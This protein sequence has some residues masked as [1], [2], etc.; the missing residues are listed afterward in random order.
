MTHRV[1]VR[2]SRVCALLVFVLSTYVSTAFA[3]GLAQGRPAR[4]YEPGEV[5]VKF[6]RGASLVRKNGALGRIRGRV[7]KSIHT[8][9]MRRAGDAGIERV[10]TPMD[11]PAALRA[12][13]QDPNVE[14]AEPNW[15]YTTQIANDPYYVGGSL[16]GMYGPTTT[17]PNLYGSRAGEAWAAGHTGSSTVVVGVIDQGIQITHPDLAAN[18]WTN[19][20]ET[21]TDGSGNNKSTNGL[22]DD[23]N[24]YVDD[25]NGWD[26]FNNDKT[27]YDAGGDSHGTH[28]AGTIGGVGN[29]GAGVAG[30]NWSVKIIPAKFLGPSGGSSADAIEALDYLVDLK[31][32]YGLKLVATNNSWGGGSYSQFLHAAIIRAAKK[33]ILF[34]AAAGNAGSNNDAT[35]AYPANFNTTIA[36]GAETAASYDAVISVAAINSAGSLAGFSNYGASTV[37]LGAPG[38]DINSTFPGG[39]GSASGT[40]MA[41][42]HVTGA[43]ALFAADNPAATGAQIRTAILGNTVPSAALTGKSVTG[44]RLSVGG[45]FFGSPP[46]PPG[47]VLR[48]NC[49]GGQYVSADLGTFQADAYYSGGDIYEYGGSVGATNDPALYTNV[50]WGNTFGYNLPAASGSY[51]L[52][53]HFMEGYHSSPGQRV[54][55]V[56]VNG[57]NVLTNF[58]IVA[59]AGGGRVALVK[60]FPVTTAGNVALTF[61][62]VA[63]SPIVSAI[64]LIGSGGGGQNPPSPPGN[65]TATAGTGQVDLTWGA[66]T[67]AFSYNV[68]RGSAPGGPYGTI[69]AG[70][71]TTSYTDTTVTN[72]TTYYYVVTSVNQVA[73]S[74]P[75]NEAS[76]TPSAGGSALRIN[77]GG[78]QYVSATLGTF[79]ADAYFSG[80]D[81]YDYGVPVSGTSDDALYNS[82]RWANSFSYNLPAAS[83]SYTLKLHF[84][85][86][87]WN[88]SGQRV[89]NVAVNGSNVLTNFDIAAEA[90]GKA[91]LVKSIPATSNGGAVTV[92]FQG[93]VGAPIVSAIELIGSGGGEPPTPPSAPSGL[94]AAGGTGQVE[95]TWTAGAEAASYNVK[96]GTASGGPYGTVA[97]GVTTT[98]YTDTTVVNGTTYYYVVTSVN[99]QGE[100][101]PSNEASATPTAGGGALRI[102]CGGGQYVSPSLGTFQADAYFSGGDVYDYGVPVSGTTD[103]ALYNTV[104]WANN[105]SYNL[106][107]AGASYTLKLHFMEGYWHSPGQR[108]FNVAVNGSNVLTNFDIVAQAG[109]GK[110]ALVKTIPATSV[111]GTVTVTFQ[112]VNGAPIVSAIELIP[113]G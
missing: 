83:G 15:V 24:G 2:F 51:T 105:F 50:R 66:G 82:V 47:S 94:S 81:V 20:G 91:A 16:W 46:P 75:S 85:E 87:Y 52:K 97:T 90:G 70:V 27:V 49:G 86:G 32:R 71:T 40:S 39:Y 113:G 26:F 64:E 95:L 41:A 23:A 111:G 3:G 61:Q 112:A 45:A 58:D 88:T 54:F 68:K 28:V 65:L 38:V 84:M 11:V 93:V 72:G 53:L 22:D 57:S 69:A 34:I 31:N 110:T 25:V 89:F 103:D 43:A 12:L 13:S 18:I 100:S 55:N 77:C 10:T 60:S 1:P 35:P 48:I 29:N 7:R 74:G 108:V 21:G 17:P 6:R 79:Q 80:G 44:G 62:S 63:G 67:G 92:T 33:E 104:R 56:A 36:A 42:P 101:G 78:G 109:G 76:A 9:A 99:P 14:Y 106:P 98:S 19:P 4:A 73:E 30:V 59:Q 8:A 107:A 96:R 5:L 37:D 102:N